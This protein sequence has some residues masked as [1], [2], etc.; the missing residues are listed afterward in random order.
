MKKKSQIINSNIITKN[1]SAYFEY[2]I[3]REFEAGLVLYG[4]EVKSL[5]AGKINISDSYISI[6]NEEAYLS[7]SIFNP[8]IFVSNN[9]SCNPKRNRKLLLNKSEINFLNYNKK[10]KGYTIIAL[11]MYWKNAWCKIKI[12]LCKGKKK[13]NKLNEIKE[14]EWKINKARILKNKTVAMKH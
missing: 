14:R 6:S 7:G 12:G 11:M 13:Y 4:W 9:Y 2:F 3:E 1:K 5:R 10:Q 8:L